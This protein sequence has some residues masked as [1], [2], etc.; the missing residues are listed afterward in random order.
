MIA[1]TVMLAFSICADS[2]RKSVLPIEKYRL[3]TP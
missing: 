1:E 3:G 2:G